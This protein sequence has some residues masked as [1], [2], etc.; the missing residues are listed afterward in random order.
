VIP[1]TLDLKGNEAFYKCERKVARRLVGKM[2]SDFSM[3]EDKKQSLMLFRVY[4]IS[5][6][7]K[8]RIDSCRAVS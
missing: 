1:P 8:T 6:S 2:I 4:F 5:P 7:Y 3:I